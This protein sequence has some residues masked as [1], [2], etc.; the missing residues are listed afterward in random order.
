MRDSP[1]RHDWLAIV[2]RLALP[3]ESR[4]KWLNSN[5]WWCAAGASR[6]LRE[7]GLGSGRP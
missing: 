7:V 3:W 6:P 1:V 5:A 4:A 2:V